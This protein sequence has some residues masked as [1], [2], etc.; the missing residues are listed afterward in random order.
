M[1]YEIKHVF[2][3]YELYIDGKLYGSYDTMS[4]A[5]GGLEDYKT[6]EEHGS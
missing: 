3:H 4:E 2:E 5:V 1:L 6:H